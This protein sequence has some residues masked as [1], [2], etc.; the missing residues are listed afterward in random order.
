MGFKVNTSVTVKSETHEK[1]KML[2][3]LTGYSMSQII[4]NLVNGMCEANNEQ[5]KKFKELRD[6]RNAKD[7]QNRP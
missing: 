5:I 6:A 4:L 1:L 7:I 3:D 2:S